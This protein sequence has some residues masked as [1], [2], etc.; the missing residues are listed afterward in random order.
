MPPRKPPAR[1]PGPR[2]R[3]NLH[4]APEPPTRGPVEVEI[5]RIGGRGDGL[6]EWQGHQLYIP[7][8]L[9]G[10]RLMVKFGAHRG[11]GWEGVPVTLLAEGAGRVEPA[12][13]HF[14]S[15]GGCAVQHMDDDVYMAWKLDALTLALGRSNL[16]GAG[17]VMHP[18]AR[19]PAGAR[20]RAVMNA[21]RRGSRVWLGFN[22]AHSHRLVDLTACVVLAP[23]LVAM[24]DP[25]RQAL[26]PLLADGQSVDVALT[27]LD[28]G[29]DV[30]LEG[31]SRPDLRALEHLAAFA[32]DYDLA[33][34]SWRARAGHP[35]EPIAMR[36][37]GLLGFGT[38]TV[39]PAPGA[40]LQ[41][42]R[43]GEAALVAAVLG[44]I[45]DATEVADLFAGSGTLSFPLATKAKVHAVESDLAAVDALYGGARQTDGRVTVERRD[46]FH[47]PLVPYDL[48]RFQAVVFD[49][50]RAG[51]QAQATQIAASGVSR[52]VAVSC[53]PNSFARDAQ[54]LIEGGFTLTDIWPVDQF[55]WSSHMELVGWFSR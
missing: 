5:S 39:S 52:V 46:L 2:P 38:V 50:P 20:R 11:D 42:S 7:Q 30:V 48:N 1:R 26:A 44:G 49:P 43:E 10:D 17:M 35:A 47:D 27:L 55:L 8:T 40:F 51:A 36:R 16:L 9:V 37:S 23:P 21:V 31:L 53:N 19:T 33:R 12:C 34:L 4:P 25:L 41:A 32:G 54:V 45:G 29:V 13:P 28:D 14:G 15:C 22:E 3:P 24:I 6:A 18:V